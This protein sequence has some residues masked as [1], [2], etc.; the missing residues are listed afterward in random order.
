MQSDRR[1]RRAQT[2]LLAAEYFLDSQRQR[3]NASAVVLFE[4]SEPLAA[5]VQ[6]ESERATVE[7][8][9]REVSLGESESDRDLFIHRVKLLGREFYLA[10]LDARL[11]SV[12]QVE[13]TLARIFDC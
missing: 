9:M 4:G 11:P 10:S 2:P 8:M 3:I 5:S 12:R 7:A 6:R 1:R 13:R